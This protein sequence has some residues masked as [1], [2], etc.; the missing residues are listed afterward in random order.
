[1]SISPTS[2]DTEAEELLL[3]ELP[4]LA[5]VSLDSD[6]RDGSMWW[7][8]GSAGFSLGLVTALAV[9]VGLCAGTGLITLPCRELGGGGGAFFSL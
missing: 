1:V 8:T 9:P 3:V 6:G 7:P 4:L 5:E 2:S